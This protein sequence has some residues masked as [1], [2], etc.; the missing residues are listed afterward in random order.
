MNAGHLWSFSGGKSIVRK[1]SRFNILYYLYLTS[2]VLSSRRK[3]IQACKRERGTW[4]QNVNSIW[5]C[6]VFTCIYDTHIILSQN[7][8]KAAKACSVQKIFATSLQTLWNIQTSRRQN[9]M[10]PTQI[11]APPRPIVG[12]P[13]AEPWRRTIKCHPNRPLRLTTILRSCQNVSCRARNQCGSEWTG[14]LEKHKHGHG[15]LR[16][17]ASHESCAK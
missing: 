5:V 10:N 11:G 13:H 3:H 15:I 14:T 16:V 1:H 2:T 4:S 8:S 9:A 6:I 17:P 7:L 12:Q